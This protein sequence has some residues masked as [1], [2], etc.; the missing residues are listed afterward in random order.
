[1]VGL[2][3]PPLFCVCCAFLVRWVSWL[4]L[5]RGRFEL[6]V[7][8]TLLSAGLTAGR[9]RE[10]PW[11]LAELL[12]V[13]LFSRAW[14][15]ALRALRWWVSVSSLLALAYCLLPLK[16]LS[17]QQPTRLL[18]SSCD[19][20]HRGGGVPH[21]NSHLPGE[22]K[23]EKHISGRLP[24]CLKDGTWGLHRRNHVR[25]HLDTLRL[26][27]HP[28]HHR[29]TAQLKWRLA[30]H[31]ESLWPLRAPVL[32]TGVLKWCEVFFASV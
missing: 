15:E 27:P 2:G 9:V 12:S 22:G 21:C 19:L 4:L 10:T 23:A 30:P 20:A 7:V 3:Q 32:W 13:S 11:E 6:S 18:C 24:E 25:F 26:L 28:T 1:M 29:C 31:G 17:G 14:R 5:C 8:Q 16:S